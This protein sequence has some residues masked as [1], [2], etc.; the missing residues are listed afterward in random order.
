ML[1]ACTGAA[2]DPHRMSSEARAG[3]SIVYVTVPDDAVA[4]QL[5][6]G[7]VERKLAACVNIV[8]GRILL[9]F[10]LTPTRTC[11]APCPRRCKEIIT[12][13]VGS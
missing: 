6:K 11:V 10:S 9:A 8:P 3:A 1:W 12:V 4:K 7:L 13:F 5:S 2:L